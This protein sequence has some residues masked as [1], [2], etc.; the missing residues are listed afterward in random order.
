ML[1]RFHGLVGSSPTCPAVSLS[2]SS[3]AVVAGPEYGPAMHD[4]PVVGD[5][6]LARFEYVRHRRVLDRVRQD[7][8][9]RGCLAVARAGAT[10]VDRVETD[11]RISGW[12]WG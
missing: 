9:R 4:P 1:P 3:E 10:L 2:S 7:L 12:G 11:L 5:Q 8:Q 6:Q